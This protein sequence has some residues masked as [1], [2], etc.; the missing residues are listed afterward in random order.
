MEAYGSFQLH[1]SHKND[2]VPHVVYT[3][4]EF[5]VVY[6]LLVNEWHNPTQY[7]EGRLT[8]FVTSS[9]ETAF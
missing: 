1:T 9:V 6:H 2:T 3:F 7:N 5:V 4:F 8:V